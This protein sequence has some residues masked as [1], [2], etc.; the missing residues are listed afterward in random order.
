MNELRL[1]RTPARDIGLARGS[2]RPARKRS[3]KVWCWIDEARGSTSPRAL[4]GA[5]LGRRIPKLEPA[6]EG[7]GDALTGA[8][9]GLHIVQHPRRKKHELARLQ[10][11]VPG[12]LSEG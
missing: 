4:A 9:E 6:I 7:D 10:P 2:A 5:G 1:A 3:R 12:V 11:Q 8:L